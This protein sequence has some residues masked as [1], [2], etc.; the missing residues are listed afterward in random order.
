MGYCVLAN[1][2]T[3]KCNQYKIQTN[4]KKCVKSQGV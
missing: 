3:S 2:T 1:D 4:T